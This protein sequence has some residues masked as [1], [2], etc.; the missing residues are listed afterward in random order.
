[1]DSSVHR[2]FSL[3]DGGRSQR[4]TECRLVKFVYKPTDDLGITVG[5]SLMENQPQPRRTITRFAPR[6]ELVDSIAL[7]LRAEPFQDSI[8][9]DEPRINEWIASLS[10][11]DARV[12]PH[13]LAIRPEL[14][15]HGPTELT[16]YD[17]ADEANRQSEQLFQALDLWAKANPR[18]KIR[19]YGLTFIQRSIRNLLVAREIWLH[20]GLHKQ[21][22][23]ERFVSDFRLQ[24]IYL[25]YK[26]LR[27]QNDKVYRMIHPVSVYG[28]STNARV[29]A[30]NWPMIRD[31]L[32]NE[33]G[34]RCEIRAIVENAP[35]KASKNRVVAL[36]TLEE[37]GVVVSKVESLHAVA[38]DA[39]QALLLA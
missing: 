15:I 16:T 14:T 29:L 33:L 30:D 18:P 4:S 9:R 8:R 32:K 2:G 10:G 17:F 24:K 31:G 21:V 20:K 6:V 23:I 27:N 38:A 11:F 19:G 22:S 5:F 28:S 26:D 3:I 34:M 13:C 1:M 37:A 36:R 39:E 25:A 12:F 35:Q 7:A